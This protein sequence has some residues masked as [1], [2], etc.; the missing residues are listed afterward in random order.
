V[1]NLVYALEEDDLMVKAFLA[2]YETLTVKETKSVKAFS[3]KYSLDLTD[4]LEE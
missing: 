4:L 2:I 1:K 3:E